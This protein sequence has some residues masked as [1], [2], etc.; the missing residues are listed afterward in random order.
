[1]VPEISETTDLPVITLPE[2]PDVTP[3]T[4]DPQALSEKLENILD[5]I[6]KGDNHIIKPLQD[7]PKL[8]TPTTYSPISFKSFYVVRD[9]S[10]WEDDTIDDIIETMDTSENY[11]VLY[12][13]LYCIRYCMRV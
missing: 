2:I 13:I 5:E 7:S 4:L 11:I 8:N 1:V 6:E 10:N 12:K 9:T 3:Q